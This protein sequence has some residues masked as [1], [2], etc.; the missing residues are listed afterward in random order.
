MSK[1]MFFLSVAAAVTFSLGVA[2]GAVAQ[3]SDSS[4][5]YSATAVHVLPG[6]PDSTGLV[7]KSGQK[8]RLEYDQNGQHVVQILLPEQG[9]MYLLDP[10][11]RSYLEILGQQMPAAMDENNTVPC[12]D[13]SQLAVCQ[14]VG[15]DTVSG[16]NVERWIL[17]AQPQTKPLTILWDP[18]RRHALR[19][20][21]PDGSTMSLKFKAMVDLNGRSTEHWTMQV[22]APGKET[23]TG[24][25]WF[26]PELRV[27][28]REEL[29]GGEIR[30]LENITVGAVDPAMFQVPEGWQ[31]RD[32]S[33][34]ATPQAPA[35]AP[36]E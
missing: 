22:L 24:G 14:R 11:S 35:T 36:T 16:I 7:V 6:Q 31:K 30:R 10:Q 8:M 1:R 19:Q 2:T 12:S 17:A 28:V 15:T 20:D 25:W 29:P 34:I 27:V 13:Q 32:P 4:P 21:F 3:Q 23:L 26:D 33:A 18:T 5:A 9:A